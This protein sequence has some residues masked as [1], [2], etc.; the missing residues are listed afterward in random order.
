MNFKI[1]VS[2]FIFTVAALVFLLLAGSAEARPQHH[3]RLHHRV[4]VVKAKAVQPQ[5]VQYCNEA[6]QDCRASTVS[7]GRSQ[8]ASVKGAKSPKGVKASSYQSFSGASFGL[9]AKARSYL[10]TN[11]TGWRSLWCAHFMAMIAPATAA[12][13]R[14]PNMAKSWLSLPRTTAHV[15]AIAITSRSGGGH[16]GVVTGFDEHG[17]PTIISGNHNRVVGEGVYPRSR[18]IAYVEPLS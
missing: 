2:A 10:G 17:N 8:A 12:H 15:G 9:E 16:I 7:S 6:E 18:V 14:N 1:A 4:H 3:K 5:A 11:P 13:V